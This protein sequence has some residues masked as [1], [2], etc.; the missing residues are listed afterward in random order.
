MPYNDR[1]RSMLAHIF[2]CP[3]RPMTVDLA[4]RKLVVQ[5]L[6]NHTFTRP[7]VVVAVRHLLRR[8]L[9]TSDNHDKEFRLCVA[10]EFT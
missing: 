6:N 10:S 3:F 4:T 8:L 2:L 7:N 1:F 5:A 9:D